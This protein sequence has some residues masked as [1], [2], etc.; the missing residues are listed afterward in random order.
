MEELKALSVAKRVVEQSAS[1]GGERLAAAQASEAELRSQLATTTSSAAT[2]SSALV[3]AEAREAK[4]SEELKAS[5]A[6]AARTKAHAA[7]AIQQAH[8]ELDACRAAA[9]ASEGRVCELEA[10]IRLPPTHD[11]LM[12]SS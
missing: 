2:S 11:S 6:D 9:R 3:A 10:E 5:A 8:D 12:A 4:L 7:L 1:E